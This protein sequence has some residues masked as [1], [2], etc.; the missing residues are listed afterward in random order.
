MEQRSMNDSIDKIPKAQKESED[1]KDKQDIV[2]KLMNL[3]HQIINPDRNGMIHAL[4]EA[5]TIAGNEIVQTIQ[6][7]GYIYTKP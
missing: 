7:T 3:Q 2:E 5:Q 4:M 1:A 6:S